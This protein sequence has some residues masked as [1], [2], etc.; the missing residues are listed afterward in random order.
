M[1]GASPTRTMQPRSKPDTRRMQR[2]L[3]IDDNVDALDMLALMLEAMGHSVQ[4]VYNPRDALARALEFQPELVFLDL[5][6]PHKSGYEVLE[7][8]RACAY[9]RT[10]RVFALTGSSAVEERTR[11][12][13]AGFDGHLSKPVEDARLRELL[14]EPN[15][16]PG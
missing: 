5:A 8:L 3:L 16:E 12:A 6:M 15:P 11:T 10:L 14:A 13:A 9:T 1:L 7:E 4:R 2:I